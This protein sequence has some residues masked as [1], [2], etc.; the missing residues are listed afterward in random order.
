MTQVSP[1]SV[2]QERFADLQLLRYGV[3]GFERLPL[4]QKLLI[5]YLAE[6]ALWGR[7]ILWQQNCPCGLLLRRTL[8]A[9][10]VNY[11]GPK[12]CADWQAFSVYMKRVWF[13]SGIHH[14]YSCLKFVPE[15]SRTFFLGE[16]EKLDASLLP[17]RA[18][19]TPV[20]LAERLADI[21]FR[22]EVMPR[23][24]N[25]ADGADL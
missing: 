16:V 4:R 24:V 9:V 2:L 23:R 20:Q 12:D 18:D 11:D 19:E 17:L 21:I 7:D 3:P 14:H 22:P 10:Y 13:S 6:A 25:T 8:E 1:S 5:F 15:F